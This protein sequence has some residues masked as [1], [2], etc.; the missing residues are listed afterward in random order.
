[1]TGRD[2]CL[3]VGGEIQLGLQGEG[4]LGEGYLLRPGHL[5][6]SGDELE[7]G[8]PFDLFSLCCVCVCVV[9]RQEGLVKGRT[10]DT[11]D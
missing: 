11:I 5:Q 8:I 2:A 6:M 4:R 7:R 10:T 3:E 1:M 9:G